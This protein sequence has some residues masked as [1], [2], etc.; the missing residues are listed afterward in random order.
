MAAV[1]ASSAEWLPA[2]SAADWYSF[3][4]LPRAYEHDKSETP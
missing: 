1:P 2:S 4:A 3:M